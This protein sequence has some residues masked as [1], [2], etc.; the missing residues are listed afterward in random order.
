M[1]ILSWN[2]YYV[3]MARL[4]ALKSKD[5]STKVGCV[6]VGPD[7][8]VRSTGFNGF[9]RGVREVGVVSRRGGFDDL[10]TGRPV[11]RLA[12]TDEVDPERW[13][14][15]MKYLLVE[16][17]ERNA[18]YNAARVGVPLRGCRAYLNWEPAPCVECAKAFIQAGVVEIFGPDVRFPGKGRHWEETR[19]VAD[20][21]LDEAGVRRVR[22]P[23]EGESGG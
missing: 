17:A 18:I 11:E 5:P 6:I 23:V 22:I 7:R 15:P 14:R 3:G 16:H 13:A 10:D 9:P 8:E 2:E 20:L 19:S 21:M 1:T 12:E 4:V